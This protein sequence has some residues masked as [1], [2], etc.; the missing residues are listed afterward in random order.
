MNE[1][2]LTEILDRIQ[3]SSIGVVGDFCLDAYWELDAHSAEL[4]VETGKPTHAVTKQRYSLGGAG[5]V[6]SNVVSLGVHKVFAFGVRT[7]DLFGRELLRQLQAC[8][9]DTTGMVL[10]LS[11][12]DTPVYAKP[13]LGA[14][15]QNRLD[16]GRFNSISQESANHL[17][18]ALEASLPRLDALIINQQLPNSIY[19]SEVI[20]TLN[21]LAEE[22]A[23]MVFLLDSRNRSI[24][25]HH[26]IYKINAREAAR[27]FGR[28]VEN[29]ESVP[30]SD[31]QHYARQLYT[32][33]L[34]P[35]FITHG[36]LG[37]MLF[38][39]KESAAIPALQLHG[40]TD[41]VG[42]GD[43]AVAAIACA[44]AAGATWKEAATLATYAAAVTV[45]KLRQ[46]GTA[47]PSEILEIAN[48]AG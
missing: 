18:D 9:V 7:E 20:V 40:P 38:D 12:W 45:Q 41:T 11:D 35:V 32:R 47:R 6:L 1:T 16:F 29:N 26:M 31:L 24:E 34:K 4:S 33:F 39:G 3:H 10:Q 42:A 5:N 44:L 19:T 46:T 2:R 13:Y 14:E 43:T 30:D 15:E 27:V 48:S 25:F 8:K 36:S 22:Y 21:R 23:E 17:I 28:S 37:I